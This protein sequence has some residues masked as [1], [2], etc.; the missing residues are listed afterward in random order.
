MRR[1][2]SAKSLI[3][4]TNTSGM[5][6]SKLPHMIQRAALAR[7][8]I[9]G[10][11]V[12][13]VGGLFGALLGGLFGTALP[14]EKASITLFGGCLNSLPTAARTSSAI[15]RNGLVS[16]IA[17]NTTVT[18]TNWPLAQLKPTLGLTPV[19]V[20]RSLSTERACLK[21]SVTVVVASQAARMTA[22]KPIAKILSMEAS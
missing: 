21:P 7:R 20:S 2:P 16:G 1:S 4:S 15:S 13:F 5:W 11:S 6:L 18:E 9:A 22:V 12:L 10:A 14:S 17:G 8:D 19:A 3:F